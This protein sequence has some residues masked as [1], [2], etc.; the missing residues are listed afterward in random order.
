MTIPLLT[1]KLFTPLPRPDLV[2][3]PRLIKQL[4][5]SITRKLALISAP[6]GFGKSSILSAWVQQIDDGKQIAWLSLDESDNDLT[7]FLTYVI[8][9]LQAS[10]PDFGQGVLAILQSPGELNL[11]LVLT[12]LINEI[13]KFPNNVTLVLDD[14]HVIETPQ[15]DQAITFLLD[16]LPPQMHI[17]IA[18]RIDPTMP[19]SRLRT[20][21]QMLEIRGSDLR[22]T[23]DEVTAF[24]GQSLGTDLSDQD[25]AA[26]EDRT[27]GWIAGL[28]LAA[29][30][31]QGSNHNDIHDFVNRFT[32]SDR[33]I[34][35]YLTDEVLQQC[36]GDTRNFLLQ[37]S[38]LQQM[39]ASLCNYILEISNSQTILENLEVMNL[40]LVPLDNERG[41]YRYH[42]LFAD[43]LR[44]RLK[45]IYPER[46]EKIHNRASQWLEKNGFYLQAIK[47]TLAMKEKS[48]AVD[49]IEVYAKDFLG[50]GSTQIKGLLDWFTQL[51]LELIAERPLLQIYKAWTLYHNGSFKNK[52]LVEQLLIR[53]QESLEKTNPEQHIRKTVYGHIFCMRGFLSSP[54]LQTDHHPE[55][56]LALF[57]EAI[58]LLPSDEFFVRCV[59]YIGI[60]YEYM[61]LGD[62]RN[63]FEA[64]QNAF[65]EARVATNNLA[66]LVALR[67]QAMIAFYLGK[68]E[69]AI[70]ICQSLEQLNFP[71]SKFFLNLEILT[72]VKGFILVEH[73][74][75]DTAEIELT[76]SFETLQFYNEYGTRVLGSIAM[77][78]LLLLKNKF[79][80]ASQ[81]IETYKQ[82][83]PYNETLLEVLNIQ[84]AI[85][86]CEN[87]SSALGMI[88]NWVSKNQPTFDN[89]I[90]GRGITPWLEVHHIRELTWIQSNII[91]SGLESIPQ[92]DSILTKCINYLD[93]QMEF[94]ERHGLVFRK[95]EYLVVKALALKSMGKPN[96]AID[97]VSEALAIAAPKGFRRVFLDKGKPMKRLLKG[98]PEFDRSNDFAY[99]LL[100]T[101]EQFED[102]KTPLLAQKLIEPLSE[103]ELEV[104]GLVAQGFTNREISE[105]LYLA[106]DTIKG[107]NRRIFG[108]LGVRKRIEAVDRARELG[109][110]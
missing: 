105:H 52:K 60:A 56:V 38:L 87:D 43:L 31:M 78:R 18:S 25:I 63:A 36:S 88:E 104:L 45:Q 62:T 10:N 26:L 72:I 57:Q 82:Y 21:G 103:R 7:R 80:Q 53:V 73:G 4:N 9:A 54:P 16:Y 17:I 85:S 1:T 37:T 40:F 96:Q 50:K 71:D 79:E 15:I 66:A 99:Q 48:F 20:R 65:R 69:N 30:A 49:L 12:N 76:K 35:D 110:L 51:P 2:P 32:G 64:S 100:A 77:V 13:S 67:N 98:M 14:Y 84:V 94:A 34:Q 59:V 55:D 58:R 83:W 106:L 109:L 89:E 81:F 39:N 27:E 44:H 8:A 11:E 93:R 70:E 33:Y 23:V 24:L 75:V 108:K 91:L 29:L 47:H 95:I 42:H 3:R 41:W 28:Q 86:C 107:H 46:I 102:I 74:E 19:L 90:E 101:F 97:N 68:P 5:I 61:H 22:F 92:D 6:A